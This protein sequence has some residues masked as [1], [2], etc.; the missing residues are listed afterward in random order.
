MLCLAY[1]VRPKLILFD[2]PLAGLSEDNIGLA[3][4]FLSKIKL[5]GTGIF[6]IEHNIDKVI[7]MVN[8]VFMLKNGNV[9]ESKDESFANIKNEIL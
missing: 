4:E 2:E 9:F 8:R 3:V 7:D 1:I 5:K 6:I